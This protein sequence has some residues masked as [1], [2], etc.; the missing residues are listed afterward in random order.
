M[1]LSKRFVK[2]WMT[3]DPITVTSST[4]VPQV[5]EMM[6]TYKIRHIPVVDEGE[7]VAIVSFGDIRSAN[8]SDASGLSIY[9]LNF[10]LKNLDIKDLMTENPVTV[11][12][13]SLISEAA[14]IMLEKKFGGLPVMQE[15][16][17]VG[18][19]TESDIFRV[20]IDAFS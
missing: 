6:Q 2:D 8:P 5:H 12:A 10:L 20:V 18:I 16:K 3:P 14:R 17:L 11:D 4:S 15:G 9:E 1:T 7:L 19:V 13:E